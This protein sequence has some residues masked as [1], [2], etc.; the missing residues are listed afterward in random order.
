M[1]SKLRAIVAL[2]LLGLAFTATE[3][4][5]DTWSGWSGGPE[6]NP[7][8]ALRPASN[9]GVAWSSEQS[10]VSTKPGCV[11]YGDGVVYT[12]VT[13]SN[14]DVEFVA[15]DGVDGSVIWPKGPFR[16][17]GVCP[18]LR[19]DTVYVSYQRKADQLWVVAALDV[20]DGE[21]QWEVVLA[22]NRS[23]GE[24][25]VWVA[26]D[27]VYVVSHVVL[28]N[29]TYSSFDVRA[30][31][32]SDGTVAW[33]KPDIINWRTIL[34]AAEGAVV[35]KQADG[36][37]AFAAE[38]GASLGWPLND[39]DAVSDYPVPLIINAGTV[40]HQRKDN[41]GN[42]SILVARDLAGGTQKWTH[43]VGS[44]YAL[45]GMAVDDERLYATGYNVPELPLKV[46]G[47]NRD[48][49]NQA[50]SNQ[51]VFSN[52]R[53]I[54]LLGG[55]LYLDGW[56][57]FSV[58]NDTGQNWTVL[59]PASGGIL[60]STA[61]FVDTGL[62]FSNAAYGDGRFFSWSLISRDESTGP[63][64]LEARADVVAP[65]V[66][67]TAPVTGEYRSSSQTITWEADDGFDTPLAWFEIAVNGGSPVQ[68]DGA[69]R[70]EQLTGLAAGANEIEVK[71]IDL[72][73]NFYSAFRTITVVPSPVPV[74]ELSG[75]S[76]PVLTRSPVNFAASASR[77]S[78]LDGHL[79]KFEWDLDGDGSF[80]TDGGPTPTISTEPT[81]V[82]V[83]NVRVR[84]TN[85]SGNSA[86]T[87]VS[88]DVR[89]KPLPGAGQVGVSINEA[90]IFTNDPVVKLKVSWPPL[91]TD[92]FVSNDGGFATSSSFPLPASGII[93]WTLSSSGPERL[94][95]QVYVRY[96]N[97]GNDT[98]TYS[99][100]IILDETPPVIQQ[101][102][103][104]ES[105]AGAS[106]IAGL[107]SL[108]GAAP[109]SVSKSRRK[110]PKGVRIRLKA[111]DATSGVVAVQVARTRRVKG[112]VVKVGNRL[113]QVS[114]VINPRVR[115]RPKL[116][117][118]KDAAGNWS[119]FRRVK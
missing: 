5:A 97:A 53:H 102:T 111:R 71:A 94:P 31:R 29:G 28:N 104:V 118:V 89:R 95:K 72:A 36:L 77:D 61:G 108:R 65:E 74:A 98:V 68:V 2:G 57:D 78:V 112:P 64:K 87:S 50:W 88:V 55:R 99:D 17:F 103:V 91:A 69:L 84:V 40:F 114:R 83:G 10:L 16:N 117:R 8:R 47:L 13:E 62:S 116:I 27:R 20:A 49:G 59:D 39:R 52:S 113:K 51:T 79:T 56:T 45:N 93:E 35:V 107:R 101:A 115:Y 14:G 96:L 90:A 43:S 54:H 110:K 60:G 109:A 32:T 85:D 80:E 37:W 86:V 106:A 26:D 119:R 42:P 6:G 105:G 66:S 44:A 24:G 23:L 19:G 81:A 33:S 76:G 3:A 15:V 58:W 82:G 41:N 46:V 25:R 30:L 1:R 38:D 7:S 4:R 73:G 48:S 75:P 70:S 12:P 67:V 92:L 21:Q 63:F 100:D 34:A 11:A 18:A 9:L 22:A